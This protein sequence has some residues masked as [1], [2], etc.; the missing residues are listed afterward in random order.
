MWEAQVRTDGLLRGSRDERIQQMLAL[1]NKSWKLDAL[2]E[3]HCGL[4]DH[5]HDVREAAMETL[6]G[7]AAR[8][9]VAISISPEMLLVQSRLPLWRELLRLQTTQDI[10]AVR[11]PENFQ[12]VPAVGNGQQRPGARSLNSSDSTRWSLQSLN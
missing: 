4:L 6:L 1:K 11:P 7:L 8:K 3:I 12:P 10:Q 2:L 9:T 5:A